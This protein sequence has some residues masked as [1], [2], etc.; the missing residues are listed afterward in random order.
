MKKLITVRADQN[1]GGYTNMTLPLIRAYAQRI[2]ADFK[3]LEN[4]YANSISDGLFHYRIMEIGNLLKEYDR[5]L[6]LDADIILNKNVPDIFEFVDEDKVATVFEDKGSR[7]SHRRGLMASIQRMWGDVGW[8]EGYINSGCILFS[9][10]HANIFQEH[11]GQVWNDFG[12]DDVHMGYMIHKHGH[13]IQELPFTFNHMTMFS[14]PWNG[15][16]NRF[17]SYLLHYAGKGVFEPRFNEKISQMRSD[18]EQIYDSV[19][20]MS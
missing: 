14:E 12:F 11:E 2:G 4:N 6:N 8:S 20:S 17:D 16:A 1:I 9:K 3:L 13:Q 10:K 19:P 18:Y 15:H 5:V 7:I